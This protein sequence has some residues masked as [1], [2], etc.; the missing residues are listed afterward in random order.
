MYSSRF[1]VAVFMELCEERRDFAA[2]MFILKFPNAH[3]LL[4]RDNKGN[5]RQGN[6]ESNN[7]YHDD[8]AV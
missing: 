7:H 2:D 5:N 8:A 1:A 4:I 6:R 3:S